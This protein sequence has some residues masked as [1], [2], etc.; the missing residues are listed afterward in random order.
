MHTSTQFITSLFLASISSADNAGLGNF[1]APGRAERML[2]RRAPTDYG[3]FHVDCSGAEA[4][5][6]NACYYVNCNAANDPDANKITYI[7]PNGGPNKDN[8]RNRYESGCQ[9]GNGGSVCGNYPFSQKWIDDQS[10]A[11][12]YECDEWPPAVSQQEQFDKKADK[13]SLRCMPGGEN[14][15]LGAKISNFINN[16]GGPYPNRPSGQMSRDDFFHVTFDTS[17]A[18][19]S[20][21][22]LKFCIKQGGQID[23][24]NDGFQFGLTSKPTKNGKISAHYDPEGS[25]NH[26]ALQ[27]TAYKDLFQC[28]IELTRDGDSDFKDVK[29]FNWENHG[30]THTHDCTINSDTGTCDLKGLP[31]TL[32]LGRTGAFNTKLTFQ[33]ADSSNVNNFKWDSESS[34]NG[35]GPATDDG[36]Q[37]RFCKVDTSGNTQKFQC[38][39]PCYKKANGQ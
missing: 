23:C 28:S 13:N 33:Y 29:L 30:V 12:S 3:T 35:K 22:K 20:N 4:A 17:K 15:S 19:T 10:K 11:T 25:D 5:C 16:K 27:N 14:G 1:H 38:W 37:F 9:T 6:N 2:F 32:T 39:F 7:G 26:Y 8:Q 24:G 21:S 31:N 34:G 18:D 36:A